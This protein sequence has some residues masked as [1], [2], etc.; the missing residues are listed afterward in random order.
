[1]IERRIV[2]ADEIDQTPIVS[3]QIVAALRSAAGHVFVICRDP[4]FLCRR[5]G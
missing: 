3:P 4:W 5:P 1:M 2:D